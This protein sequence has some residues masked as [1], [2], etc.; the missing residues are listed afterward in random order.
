M[1][2]TAPQRPGRRPSAF[3]RWVY[4]PIGFSKAYNFILF[5]IFGGAFLGFILARLQYLDFDGVFCSPNPRPGH[6]AAPGECYYYTKF[7]RYKIG[8]QLHLF[9]V[10]P[11]GLLALLQFVPIL[12]HKFILFHRISGYISL[13]LF[14][15]GTVGALMIARH[16]FG[17]DLATQGWT[18]FVSILTMGSFLMSYIN[19]KR[20]Q[21]EEHRAW[22]LRG[23][24][25]AGSILTARLIMII[26]AVAISGSNYYV[27]RPCA[28][29]D[30]VFKN[31]DTTLGFYPGCASFYSGDAEQEV[32]VRAKM[33]SGNPVESAAA[34]GLSFAMALWIAGA[35]HAIGVEIYLHLTP[36]EKERLRNVSYQ[37]QLE[38]G[39]RNPGSA[40]LT[41]DR[42][43][44]AEGWVPRSA[45]ER[46]AKK[47]L[48]R[49]PSDGSGS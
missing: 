2:P 35:L 24:F 11:A 10:L 43:G 23:W 41:S 47:R 22:M 26:S 6:S 29:I 27:T 8:I 38:A 4:R 3:A 49:C 42:L 20:L 31:Q 46:D 5:F 13:T 21:I 12:R 18:G 28:V 9:C 7:P 36:R 44:D 33:G 45:G 15:I 14:T 1:S 30:F 40:G 25:Y 16:S 39:M 48:A 19:I 17:G 37:R 34:L 32:I